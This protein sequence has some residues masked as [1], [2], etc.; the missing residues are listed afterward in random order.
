MK[1][2]RNCGCGG[3]SNPYPVYPTYPG[4]M[5]IMNQ[6]MPIIPNI[7]PMMNQGMPNNIMMPT[8][9]S[10]SMNNFNN[11]YSNLTTQVN[12]LERRVT[13]LEGIVNSGTTVT[14]KYNDSNYYMV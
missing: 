10:S 8:V 14:P 7:N 9:Q 6:G 11:E 2:D 13:R 3:N 4:V 5:P 12:N 1:K